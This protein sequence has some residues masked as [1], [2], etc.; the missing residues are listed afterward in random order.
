MI[1]KGANKPAWPYPKKVSGMFAAGN[2]QWAK[3]I[4]GHRYHFGPWADPKSALAAYMAEKDQLES[5]QGRTEAIDPNRITVRELASRFILAKWERVKTGELS[6]R[7]Y[8]DYRRTARK[9]ME[10]LG[11]KTLIAAIT[12]S[13]FTR[14]QTKLGPSAARRANETTW[15]RTIFKWGGESELI[16]R[17]V[18][19][20][21][22]FRRPKAKDIRRAKNKKSRKRLYAPEEVY[23][24][25]INAPP[26]MKAMIL[27]AINGG[28][29]NTDLSA[30]AL[31]DLD[32]SKGLIDNVRNKTGV[33]RTV[34]LW[35]E[36][37]TALKEWFAVR[38]TPKPDARKFAFVTTTGLPLVCIRTS[39]DPKHKDGFRM[40]KA[41]SVAREFNGYVKG[42]GLAGKTFYDLR[43][44]FR[45]VAESGEFKERTIARIM[46]HIQ[47]DIG[48]EYI[49]DFS[50][51]KLR[52][53]T[54]HVRAWYLTGHLSSFSTAA[55]APPDT[56]A[57]PSAS[58]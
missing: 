40:T 25:V 24:L 2:G 29:G 4:R 43:H 27:L 45:T 53:V 23:W 58:A 20:G 7:M 36:T 16:S 3:K 39:S 44:T 13:D 9:L 15:V 41:D 50:L 6:A 32:L 1:P 10:A 51:N 48:S 35:P 28:M 5:G 57:S 52:A 46:G 18:R 37:V 11:E 42:M 38:P 33:V 34:P 26:D 31:E 12:P 56:S 14:L 55:V 17:T 30:L 54:D 49:H 19:F 21:P 22:D 8:D 47:S